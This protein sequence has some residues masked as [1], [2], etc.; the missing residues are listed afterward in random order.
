M[1]DERRCEEAQGTQKA[2]GSE[3]APGGEP[4]EARS[5]GRLYRRLRRAAPVSAVAL[6][7]ACGSGSSPTRETPEE[8]PPPG[9]EVFSCNIP[10]D[11]ILDGGAGRNGIFRLDNPPM[12]SPDDP[13]AA[14]LDPHNRVIGIRLGDEVLAVP[15]NILRFHESVNLD[16]AG[17]SIAATYCP[18]TGSSLVFDRAPIG[19]AILG[20][21]G[22]ILRNNLILFDEREETNQEVLWSQMLR[23]SICGRDEPAQGTQL[24]LVPYVEMTWE[25]WKE[26]NPETVVVSSNTGF[27]RDYTQNPNGSYEN[28]DNT[29]LFFPRARQDD[30]RPLKERL[31]GIPLARDGGI[32]FTFL[33]LGRAERFAIEQPTP[34]GR[35]IVFWN[36]T[37]QGAAAYFN[38]L[39]GEELTFEVTS[40]G[41]RD[42]ETG[43][44]WNILGDAIAGPLEGRRL[45]PFTEAYTAFWFAW[46][47][48][49]PETII[50]AP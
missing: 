49:Q 32:A 42:Q 33:E 11:Q 23:R 27:N 36:R 17:R 22:L 31:L 35:L 28:I 5:V 14:F 3:G 43:S 46:A 44:T 26:L 21:S 24:P 45:E 25:S 30:R 20:V 19:G 6:L 12:V 13:G 1:L 50:W 2:Y 29:D 34:Y 15:L 18:L 48:F 10:R 8:P 4:G 38:D 7:L 40:E 16:V 47:D 41:F 39:D 9:D 37:A